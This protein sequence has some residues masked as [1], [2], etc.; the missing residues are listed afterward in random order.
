MMKPVF[1]T[2][3]KDVKNQDIGQVGIKAEELKNL[4]SLAL[5]VPEGFVVT[6]EFLNEFMKKGSLRQKIL[7]EFSGVGLKDRDKIIYACETVKTAFLSADFPS[8][9]TQLLKSYYH[10]ISGEYDKA[11]IVR[12]SKLSESAPGSF[13]KNLYFGVK[14]VAELSHIIKL[15]YSS[16]FDFDS[17]V[18]A[19]KNGRNL[20]NSSIAVVVQA[21]IEPEVSGIC[22]T[23]NPLT[24]S[25]SEIFIEAG[26]GFPKPIISGEVESD[27]Y[28][29]RRSDFSLVSKEVSSQAWQLTVSGKLK[30]S[31][32][33]K[34]K[35]KISGAKLT[36][37][38]KAGQK[39]EKLY[40]SQ[41][42]VEWA[43]AGN[44]LY[45][46][47]ASPLTDSTKNLPTPMIA[48]YLDE[49]LLLQGDSFSLGLAQGVVKKIISDVFPS[50]VSKN[51]VLVVKDINPSKIEDYLKAAAIVA[52]NGSIELA[53]GTA[54]LEL[55]IPIV[56]NAKMALSILS[57]GEEV[58]VDG[59]E[60]KVYQGLKVFQRRD[61][62]ELFQ[63]LK[64]ATKVYLNLSDPELAYEM[65]LRNSDGVGLLR[66]EYVMTQIGIHPRKFVQERK[67]KVFIKT[68]SESLASFASA[69]RDR[70]VFYRFCDFRSDEYKALKG[71]AEFEK[72][73]ANPTLGLRGASR[74]VADRDGFALELEAVKTVRHKLGLKNLHV[75]LP[76]VRNVLELREIKRMLSANGLRRSGSFKVW[77]LC[78]VPS[79][80]FLIEKYLEEGVDGVC[81]GSNNL[82]TLILGVDGNN[83][84]VSQVFSEVDPALQWAIDKV[85]SACRKY[86][87]HVSFSGL[88]L[89]HFPELTKM[90]VEKGITSVTVSPDILD[91]TRGLVYEAERSFLTKKLS[92]RSSA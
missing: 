12:G 79:N 68:L 26:Y 74:M 20:L 81:I 67:G 63:T 73:E 53:A 42:E 21:L 80:V 65:A 50:S 48:D 45:V 29:L 60:G 5:K 46:L 58:T 6:A 32:A 92:L 9:L 51:Q 69:F 19:K 64:T 89:A 44:S 76:F 2:F 33:F 88:A 4:M 49:N 82:T 28:V 43:I 23:R 8:N 59:K 66:A 83:P 86:K 14:G 91:R 71:G 90:L 13:N 52:E 16:L 77:M 37:I 72:D 75:V 15:I 61:A 31:K 78:E 55:G 7:N 34:S 36:E 41:V 27:K 85:I 35:K 84:K 47:S 18:Y 40:S 10:S 70:P 38:S 56:V 3:L 54:L 1:V 25:N 11:L 39:I 30:I 87:V 62:D 24:L 22:F 17:V 57:D